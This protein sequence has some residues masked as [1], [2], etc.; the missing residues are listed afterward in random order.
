MVFG[1][2]LH[3]AHWITKASRANRKQALKVGECL[4][5]NPIGGRSRG[6]ETL[7]YYEI[8]GPHSERSESPDVAS[9]SHFQGAR[10]ALSASSSIWP[11][12]KHPLRRIR[13]RVF[14]IGSSFVLRP[15][16]VKVRDYCPTIVAPKKLNTWPIG[17]ATAVVLLPANNRPTAL[18]FVAAS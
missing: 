4:F 15:K 6:D 12:G 3:A 8:R 13:Q 2:P 1:F 5:I 7:I 16:T 9:Y 10:K 14:R 11:K 18:G 17:F